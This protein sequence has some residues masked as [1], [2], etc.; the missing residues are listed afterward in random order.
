MIKMGTREP[1]PIKLTANTVAGDV[2]VGYNLKLARNLA[3]HFKLSVTIAYPKFVR[4]FDYTRINPTGADPA[5]DISGY[6]H[7]MNSVN[8]T[9]GVTVH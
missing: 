6:C 7:N 9:V 3:A 4:I 5:P 8:L 2:G 1:E